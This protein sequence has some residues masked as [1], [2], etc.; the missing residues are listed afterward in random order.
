MSEAVA[1]RG[2]DDGPLAIICG[3]GSLPFAVADAVRKRGRRVV[4]FAIRGWA[5]PQRVAAY[6]HHWAGSANSAGSAGLR[7][8]EGC[9][10]VVFIGSIVRPAIWQIRPDFKTAR[11]LPRVL[12]MFRGGDDHLLTGVA[13]FSKS[14]ASGSSGRRRS[15]RNP[16]AGRARSAASP[17]AATMP[18]SRTALRLLA[19]SARSTSARRWSWP[20]RVLAVEAAEGTDLHARAHR[21]LAPQRAH[22]VGVGGGVLVKA[23]SRARIGAS[24]CR[25]SARRRSK[26]RR[27]RASP[28]SRSSPG[29]PSS[30]SPSASVRRGA[31]AA[32]RPRRARAG[33]RAMSARPARPSECSTSFSSPARDPATGS[34]PR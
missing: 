9:R 18:I 33:G 23:R 17:R 26:A 20:R 8:E 30:P 10:D 7:A 24:I 13:R 1:G 25:R 22:A 6:P 19:R 14:T 27:A 4:L 12:R 21:G 32:V 11:L 28:A 34:A 5:D 3:G 29:A 2:T 31:R 15:P 16:D